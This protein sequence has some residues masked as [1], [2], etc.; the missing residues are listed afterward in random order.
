MSA[1][2]DEYGADEAE[3]HV[4]VCAISVVLALVPA[5]IPE[6]PAHQQERNLPGEV[7]VGRDDQR[8][9]E[10]ENVRDVVPLEPDSLLLGTFGHRFLRGREYSVFMLCQIL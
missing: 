3:R 4:D 1:A 5:E 8:Q 6:R 10:E 7:E 9:V 2:E